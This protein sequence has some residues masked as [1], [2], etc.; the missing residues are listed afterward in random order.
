MV[1]KIFP[2]ML[3]PAIELHPWKNIASTGGIA[4]SMNSWALSIINPLTPAAL[5]IVIVRETIVAEPAVWA[6]VQDILVTL[7]VKLIKFYSQKP[8]LSGELLDL[9]QDLKRF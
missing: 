6:N 2:T 7:F 9:H 1:L 3:L 4:I 8:A 5:A